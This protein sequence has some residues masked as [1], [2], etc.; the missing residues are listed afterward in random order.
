MASRSSSAFWNYLP[1]FVAVARTQHLR[2]GAQA[3]RV[4][5]SALS[6][7]IA[8]L[9]YHIGYRLFERYGRRLELTA[10]GEQLLDAL[11]QSMVLLDDTFP[12]ETDT[13]RCDD[14]QRLSERL[15]RNDREPAR[16]AGEQQSF[17]D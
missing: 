8:L 1:G 4:S 15:R 12:A 9:E 6:R 2:K 5:P 16:A 11:L 13:G 7:T 3:L 14:V 10:R 17:I